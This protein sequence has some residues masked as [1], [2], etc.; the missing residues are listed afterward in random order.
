MTSSTIASPSLTSTGHAPPASREQTLMLEHSPLT[1]PEVLLEER[2]RFYPFAYDADEMLPTSLVR[3]SATSP[4]PSG[5]W[6]AGLAGFLNQGRPTETAGA[7]TDAHLR[8]RARRFLRTPECAGAPRARCRIARRRVAGRAAIFATL[9]MEAACSLGFAAPLRLGLPIR[10]STGTQGDVNIGGGSTHAWCQVYLPG[11]L[12]RVRSDQRHRRQPGFDP[13]VWSPADARCR[14]FRCTAPI[15]A[16]RWTMEWMFRLSCAPLPRVEVPARPAAA[17]LLRTVTAWSLQGFTSATV[18]APNWRMSRPRAAGMLI[19]AG[20]AIGF[21]CV[22]STPMLLQLNIHPPA[23]AIC[24][25]P[26]SCC[27]IRLCR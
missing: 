14:P 18:V 6:I 15:S 22:A 1:E 25:S 24:A 17:S 10:A 3:S 23:G 13:R 11:R 2:A 7:S 20:F 8:D 5:N 26:I 16:K 9:M 19:E 27:S 21:E 4:D 12:G